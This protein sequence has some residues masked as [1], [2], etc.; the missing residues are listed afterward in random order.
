MWAEE[1]NLFVT[2]LQKSG[3]IKL[4]TLHVIKIKTGFIILI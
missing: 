4:D 2:R 1:K 3:Q